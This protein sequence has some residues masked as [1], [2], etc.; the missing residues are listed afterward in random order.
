VSQSADRVGF[1]TAIGRA[2]L[3]ECP[4]CGTRG[5]LD[6]WFKLKE[7]CTVCALGMHRAPED[8]EW[9]GGYFINLITSQLLMLLVVVGY[10]LWTWP[11]VTWARVE[12]LAV[13]MIFASAIVSYPFSKVIWVAVEFVFAERAGTQN[14][15]RP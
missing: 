2:L 8:D 7:R 1:V 4:R 11:A 13:A 14:R 10:V 12:V 6:G 3:L 15:R 5:I 9:F